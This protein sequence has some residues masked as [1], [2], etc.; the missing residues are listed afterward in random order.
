MRER[1]RTLSA[2]C[3][4]VLCLLL[5]AA[6]THSLC[7]PHFKLFVQKA[8]CVVYKGLRERERCSVVFSHASRCVTVICSTGLDGCSFAEG[9]LECTALIITEV[10]F[11]SAGLIKHRRLSSS[12]VR[13]TLIKSRRYKAR[14]GRSGVVRRLNAQKRPCTRGVLRCGKTKMGDF[15][16]CTL[17]RG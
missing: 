1:A 17:A 16:T 2:W 11:S 14:R 8:A 15:T 3:Q 6:M 7:F 9:A 10:G 12:A 13:W 5:A 4:A